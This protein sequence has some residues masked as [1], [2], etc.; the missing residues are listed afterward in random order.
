MPARL[1]LL[2]FPLLL[3]QCGGATGRSLFRRSVPPYPEAR[4]EQRSLQREQDRERQ[5]AAHERGQSDG[6]ADATAGAARDPWRVARSLPTGEAE[7]YQSGYNEGYARAGTSTP[8]DPAYS[9]GYDYGLRDRVAGRPADPAAHAGRYD[10]RHRRSFE[11]GYQDA[12]E[13]AR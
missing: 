13:A 10:P 12:Y 8:A 5:I 4:E 3:V 7:A 1:L 11:R 6:L 2:L 9:Q